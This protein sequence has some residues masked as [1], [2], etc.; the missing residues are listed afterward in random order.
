[1][2]IDGY[3][4][5]FAYTVGA[6]CAIT[7]LK[8]PVPKTLADQCKTIMQMAVIMNKAYEDRQKLANP[9]YTPKYLTRDRLNALDVK[10]IV[11]K[12]SPEV[13]DAVAEG[14]YRLVEAE[15]KKQEGAEDR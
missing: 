7:D 13:N 11:N 12:L 8:L 15:P 2:L 5:R 6:F 14:K 1:M 9:S 3:D 4:Y 10:D